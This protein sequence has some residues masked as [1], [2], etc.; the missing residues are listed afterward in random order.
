[1]RPR[2]MKTLFAG[3]FLSLL[4]WFFGPVLGLGPAHALDTEKARLLVIAVLLV[5]WLAGT[6][7]REVGEIRRERALLAGMTAATDLERTGSAAEVALLGQRLR[8]ALKRASES[9]RADHSV[10][11]LPWYM[12]V[13]PPGAGKTTALVNSGLNFPVGEEAQALAGVGGTR[14][15]RWWFTDQAVLIETAGRDTTQHDHGAED[16]AARLG[17]LR[18][19]KRYRRR[20]P[21]NGVLV[22][23][24]LPDLAQL[25][26]ADRLAHARGLGE[27]VRELHDELGVRLPVYVLFTKADLIA[28]F[29]E[30]FDALSREERAQV[31]GMTFPEDDTEIVALFSQEFDLL[32]TRLNDRMLE[33]VHE[34]SDLHRRRLIYAFPQRIASL[35][36]VAAAFLTEFSRPSRP[37]ARPLLRGAYFTSG[38]QFPGGRGYFLARLMREVI[39]GEAGL[40]AQD[41]EAERRRRLFDYVACAG[42]AAFLLLCTSLWTASYFGNRN[43]MAQ[44]H[45]QVRRYD[46][47][48]AELA[49]RGVHD[50]DLPPVLPPLDVARNIS[51]GYADRERSPP[52]LL[53][54]GLYQGRKLNTA[55]VEFYIRTL[56]A[57]LLPRL[58]ARLEDQM[59][60][61]LANPDYLYHALKVYMI[62]GR[63]GPLDRDVV[64]RWLSAD[65]AASFQGHDQQ[66]LRDSLAKHV[67]ALLEQPLTAVALDGPLLTQVRDVLARVAPTMRHTDSKAGPY[68]R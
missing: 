66:A 33:R 12:L 59:R 63:Q 23:V 50:I 27:R 48:Y 13:G 18:L 3:L 56:N 7:I 45:G 17:F 42:A 24:S 35:R 14:H 25:S 28:G 54:F 30:F 38:T 4:V 57:L 52:I 8:E 61:H 22:A 36:E 40:V 64:E 21:L 2:L 20:P 10:N 55:A 62:L 16:S 68:G 34:E 29:V 26:E 6:L 19:L 31:W 49:A 67:D 15:C 60:A 53:T 9:G 5:L 47:Q 1:M 65:F 32:L 11:A 37:A 44:M 51:G 58:L 41:A 43:L 39:F 46:A